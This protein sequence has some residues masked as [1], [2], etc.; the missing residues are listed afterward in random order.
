MTIRCTSTCMVF[1][2]V[3]GTIP[4]I[5]AYYRQK[6]DS[7]DRK[8]W[9]MTDRRATTYNS[10][11]ALDRFRVYF[12]QHHPSARQSGDFYSTYPTKLIDL[13]KNIWRNRHE[14]KQSKLWEIFAQY[15]LSF[16]VA[17]VTIGCW[18]RCCSRHAV[19]LQAGFD[20]LFSR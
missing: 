4:G 12:Q 16:G 10:N 20:A 18:A 13:R 14:L 5:V 1:R 2:I 3:R 7:V 15:G 9:R 8:H 19:V 6:T 17:N 11:E